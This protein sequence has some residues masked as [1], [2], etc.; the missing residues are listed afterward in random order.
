[1]PGSL[2]MGFSFLR[3]VRSLLRR[4]GQFFH[5]WQ[6]DARRRRVSHCALP[7]R[8]ARRRLTPFRPRLEYLEARLAPATHT[9][10]GLGGNNLWTTAKNWTG[11]DPV[12]GDSLLFGPGSQ[13]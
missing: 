3:W 10:T 12:A 5:Q 7:F 9:W 4:V 8:M 13:Q 11:G 2:S 1:M 6:D